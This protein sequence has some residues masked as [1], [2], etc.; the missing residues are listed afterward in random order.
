MVQDPDFDLV[1]R[2]RSDDPDVYEP[3]FRELYERY[4]ERV[5]NLAWRI[6]GD[7]HAAADATQE[8]FLA[9][10]RTI[11]RFQHESRF[12]T[13]L[14]RIAVNVAIDRR[15][16]HRRRLERLD[17]ADEDGPEWEPEDTS[18]PTE[19]E[20]IEREHLEQ[21]V[22]KALRNLSPKLRTIVVLRYVEGLSY[23][24]LA[25]VL[26]CSLGTVKSRLNRAHGILEGL[27]APMLES[28]ED[29]AEDDAGKEASS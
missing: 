18:L 19:E 6:L 26:G 8:T 17:A 5:F 24:E 25:E 27:L 16:R 21:V 13:W 14:Y 23:P 12:F 20:R 11:G 22:E 10:F 28:E 9:V 29:R 4:G 7:E 1:R 3:A 15:R 2:C